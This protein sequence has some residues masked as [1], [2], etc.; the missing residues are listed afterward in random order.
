[1]RIIAITFAML[2]SIE[3]LYILI[4]E[5][6]MAQTQRAAKAFDLEMTF[7]KMEETKILMANQGLYNGFLAVG[8]PFGLFFVPS[9]ATKMV[10]LFFL[11]CVIV[12][13]IYGAMTASK[14]ILIVQGAPA[15]IATCLCVL[16][17]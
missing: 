13:A 11:G 4:L 17:L 3:H 15:F 14:K 2:V 5:M 10:T 9:E 16:F 6:F 1:M 12:A 8:I 7:L